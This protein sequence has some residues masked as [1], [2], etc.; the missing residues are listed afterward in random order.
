MNLHYLVDLVD[1][2]LL[3]F[4]QVQAYLK[5][6]FRPVLLENLDNL[7]NQLN[8]LTLDIL[9]ILLFLL[10]LFDLE[11]L[12]ILHVRLI[13][14]VLCFL[15]YPENLD[16]QLHLWHLLRLLN[17]L[18]LLGP[19]LLLNYYL[20]LSFP[21]L[22]LCVRHLRLHIEFPILAAVFP[23]NIFIYYNLIYIYIMRIT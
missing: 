23:Y 14:D 8:Q 18:V 5:Y 9:C 19:H 20:L 13:P 1:L 21:L 2:L 7:D 10:N 11:D 12:L 4:L 3:C 16:N 15:V 22:N 17:H 6:L